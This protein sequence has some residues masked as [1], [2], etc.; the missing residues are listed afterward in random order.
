MDRT[1]LFMKDEEEMIQVEAAALEAKKNYV[2]IS[3]LIAMGAGIEYM[4]I[5]EACDQ[6]Q[7]PD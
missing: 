7:I 5:Q 3:N 6:L 4:S 2:S 1:T